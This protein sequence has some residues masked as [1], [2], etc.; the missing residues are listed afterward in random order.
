MR[1]LCH[2]KHATL[3][4]RIEETGISAEAIPLAKI[5]FALRLDVVVSH[6]GKKQV[7]NRPAGEGKVLAQMRHIMQFLFDRI[8]RRIPRQEFAALA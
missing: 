8:K 3:R 1:R 4:G 6:R 7:K 2:E 5:Q